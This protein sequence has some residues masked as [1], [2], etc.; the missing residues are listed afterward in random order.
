[1]SINDAYTKLIN[2]K[3]FILTFNINAG[4]KYNFGNLNL[5][6]PVDYDND[7]KKINNL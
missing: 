7:F 5:D 4:E 6:L 1:M 2:N 3:D